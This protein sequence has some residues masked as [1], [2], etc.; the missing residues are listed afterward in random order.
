MSQ[1]EIRIQPEPTPNPSSVKFTVN[2]TLLCEQ[3]PSQPITAADF[4]FQ[5]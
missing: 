4:R 2:R 1:D 5:S 3:N